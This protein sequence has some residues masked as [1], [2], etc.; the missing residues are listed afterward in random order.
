M[1]VPW[2]IRN[3]DLERD[4]GINNIP[5]ETGIIATRHQDHLIAH[6]NPDAL[7]PAHSAG[8]DRRLRRKQ[9]TDLIH[10]RS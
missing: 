5:N 2:Y 3:V 1:N 6:V 7:S 9:P 10:H 4:L 8:I